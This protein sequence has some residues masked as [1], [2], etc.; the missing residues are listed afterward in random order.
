MAQKWKAAAALML[1]LAAGTAPADEFKL[2][3]SVAVRQEYNS[4]IFFDTSDEKDS[5]IT[6]VKPGLELL[7]RTERLDL[8][9]A[10]YVTPFYYWD[11]SDLNS[12]DQD[13]SGRVNYR[14]TPLVTI[15]AD[16][17]VRVDHQ[18]DRDLLTTGLTY[19]D[20]RRIQQRYGGKAS[21]MF[22]ELMSASVAYGYT[23]E[24]WRG[25]DA[26]D[27]I[28]DWD[29]HSVTLG[30][31]RE[32][33][34]ARGVT[35]GLLNAGWA[36]YD[37]ETSKTDYYFGTV[38]VKHRLT[39]IFNLTAD[40]GA[41]YTD[42]DF[43]VQSLAIVPPGVLAVIT[44]DEN[45][46]GWGGIGHLAVEYAGERARASLAASHDINAASGTSGVVQRTGVTFNGGYLWLEKLRVGLIAS[47]FRN[48]SENEEF[49]G[50]EINEYTYNF[51][52]SL[53]W[54]FYRDVTLE[55]GYGFTYVD[56]RTEDGNAVRSL[57]FIQL[58]YGLPLLE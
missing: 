21:W 34:A 7:N 28:E 1:V 47:A 49:T 16:A 38:G 55:A 3:P 45:S 26:G 42:S 9:L 39:E 56:D 20:N 40:V 22:T 12:V 52:P 30:L 57:A 46:S 19:T 27:D 8:R 35:V 23:R 44:E 48:K 31:S 58:A 54:E 10:G 43:K 50:T 51:I 53:R 4:N 13:Y 32:L 18:P 17:G 41:R 36:E 2:T 14:L 24:D 6:R 11:E 29:S 25:V 37:Y 5:F 15:G 33:G